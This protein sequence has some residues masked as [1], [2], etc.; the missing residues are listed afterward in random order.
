MSGGPAGPGGLS[1]VVGFDGAGDEGL[2]DNCADAV[3][4]AVSAKNDSGGHGLRLGLAVFD[5]RRPS[6]R[7]AEIV[8]DEHLTALEAVLMQV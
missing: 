5:P 2:N 7:V 8:S 6:L 4:C 3:M 1:G